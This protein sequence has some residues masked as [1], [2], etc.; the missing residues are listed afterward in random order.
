MQ[1]GELAG[2]GE[3][4]AG[5]GGLVAAAALYLVEQIEDLVAEVRGDTDAGVADV[6]FGGGLCAGGAISDGDGDRAAVGR[7]LER[8][9]DEVE[10]DLLELVRIY[11]RF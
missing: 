4:D 5:R 7:I 3:A 6:E 1:F 8:V 11:E 10:D 9:R 2:E